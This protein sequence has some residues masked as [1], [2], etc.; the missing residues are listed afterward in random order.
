MRIIST[1]E[2]EYPQHPNE[3]T[4]STEILNFN[5]WIDDIQEKSEFRKIRLGTINGGYMTAISCRQ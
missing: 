4:V 1:F 2:Y 5:L 3:L